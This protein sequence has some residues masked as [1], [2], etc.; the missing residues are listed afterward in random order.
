MNELS[1]LGQPG[2]SVKP[3]ANSSWLIT[4]SSAIKHQKIRIKTVLQ[5]TVQPFLCFEDHLESSIPPQLS[6]T[7]TLLFLKFRC[8]SFD[9]KTWRGEKKET[10]NIFSALQLL[11]N[12]FCSGPAG[13]L[14]NLTTA[15]IG[16]GPLWSP[17][18]AL[19]DI[20]ILTWPQLE[21]K[22]KQSCC[23]PRAVGPKIFS[24]QFL[25]WWRFTCS[26]WWIRMCVHE[27]SRQIFKKWRSRVP[28]A[29]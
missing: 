21:G 29:T 2:V 9:L 17:V 14:M 27:T 8:L 25:W 1:F 6:P 3:D 18:W 19:R 26:S 28:L 22:L 10:V 4:D 23:L 24:L 7:L 5:F 13:S 11:C 12:Y 15:F 20:V 16:V